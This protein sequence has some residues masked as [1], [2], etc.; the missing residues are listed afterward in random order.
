VLRAPAS[1]RGL[2]VAQVQALHFLQ[3]DD[4]GAEWRRRSRSSCTII[5]RLNCEKPLWML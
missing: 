2:G 1:W 5:R 3:E 4:V